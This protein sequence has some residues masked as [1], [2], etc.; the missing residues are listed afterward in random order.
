ML[1]YMKHDSAISTYVRHAN[2]WS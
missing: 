2:M 1:E